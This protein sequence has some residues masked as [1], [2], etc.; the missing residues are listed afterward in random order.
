MEESQASEISE[1]A[2]P[3]PADEEQNYL[4]VGP[5]GPRGWVLV[6]GALLV[7]AAVVAAFYG[8]LQINRNRPPTPTPD[9]LALTRAAA[10]TPPPSATSSPTPVVLTAT[11]TP[12]A[13]AALTPTAEPPTYTVQQG[14]TLI[15]IAARLNVDVDDL[16]AL[17]QISGETIFPN[18]VLHVPPTVTPWPETGPF[19]HTVAQGETLIS[20]ALSYQV[21]VDNLK[22]L[23]GLTSDTIFV[24]Q[25]LLI[26]AGGVR[27]P[28]P[29]PTPTPWAA[30]AITG[31]LD[32][33]Y[34]LTNV[35]GHFTLHV[36]PDTRVAA[37]DETARLADL[38]QDALDLSQQAV[39]RRLAGRFE[40][41]VADTL[42]DAPYTSRRGFSDVT[43]GR[44]FVLGDGSGSSVER[45]YFATY[46]LTP[47]VAAQ[48]LGETPS[49]LLREGLAVYAGGQAFERASATYLTLPQMCAAYLQADRL[50][51]LSRPLAFDGHLGHT[52][53]YIAVGCFT[54]YLIES[55]G[56]P[57]FD[58]AYLSG[59]LAAVYGQTPAQLESEWLATL[60]ETAPDL[61]FD[62]V[63]WTRIAADIDTAYRQLWE[64]FTGTP[65]QFAVYG[66][67]D[68]ARLALLQGRLGAAQNHLDAIAPPPENP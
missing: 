22:A 49:P 63:E 65:E 48:T 62:P 15:G 67:L 20:I 61:P 52:D 50:P 58:R 26:P 21:S 56:A 13:T 55:R 1:K 8:L 2:P 9:P 18:H 25:H 41:Y 6:V 14:D 16:R 46:N 45:L 33:V 54:Q 59:D 43:Q 19:P 37:P 23:N 51:A 40:V 7:G 28:T 53:A 5:G 38:V 30:A 3:E 60:R 4:D 36:A 68:R 64:V 10:V 31:E 17:N 11:P 34:S 47:L 66:R 12:T 39:G 29:T 42:F 27:P 35:K 32:S 57:T 44:L 24:G